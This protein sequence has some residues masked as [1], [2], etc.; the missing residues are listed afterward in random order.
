MD[1]KRD[2]LT[3]RE[4]EILKARFPISWKYKVWAFFF[5]RIFLLR[6]RRYWYWWLSILATFIPFIWNLIVKILVVTNLERLAFDWESPNMR[7]YL[8]ENKHLCETSEPIEE[9]VSAWFT[10][11]FFL[12]LSTILWIIGVI[13]SFAAQLLP[14]LERIQAEHHAVQYNSGNISNTIELIKENEEIKNE[15][16]EEEINVAE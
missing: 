1:K 2:N 15:V 9:N 14:R 7:K 6:S 5:P 8:E 11:W 3:K 10:L 16:Y 4:Q 13:W 12:I